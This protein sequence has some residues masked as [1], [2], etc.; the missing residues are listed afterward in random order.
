MKISTM[1]KNIK[2]STTQ[3]LSNRYWNSSGKPK[4]W[5][6]VKLSED[7]R[8]E[9]L[10]IG[11]H[12]GDEPLEFTV[13]LDTVSGKFIQIGVGKYPDGIREIDYIPEPS[14]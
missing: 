1:G 3:K 10:T 7:D 4:W 12:R 9:F 2:V 8:G 6:K 11:F 13:P 5:A 14:S